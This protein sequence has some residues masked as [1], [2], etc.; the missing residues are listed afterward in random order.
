MLEGAYLYCFLVGLLFVEDCS[1][2]TLS[3]PMNVAVL[4][5]LST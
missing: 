1:R 3:C 5:Y 4:T 2:H